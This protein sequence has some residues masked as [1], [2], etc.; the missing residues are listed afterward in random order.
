L[1]EEPR[2]IVVAHS[3]RV[4]GP[5]PLLEPLLE[6]EKLPW[7]VKVVGAV[8]VV[9]AYGG[10]R[11][12]AYEHWQPCPPDIHPDPEA[13][14]WALRNGGPYRAPRYRGRSGY[15]IGDQAIAKA[16]RKGGHRK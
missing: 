1:R 15:T 7:P 8:M 10:G 6:D 3:R 11:G 4:R 12:W 2:G 13:R 9:A 14:A 16:L 5:R